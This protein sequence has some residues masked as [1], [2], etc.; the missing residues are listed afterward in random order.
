MATELITA[1][2]VDTRETAV[3]LVEAC[4]D[5]PWFKVGL[6]LFSRCGPDIVQEIQSHQKKVFLDLKF[7]DIPNTVAMAV[8]AAADSGA[9]MINV[10]ALGGTAMINAARE[11]LVKTGT[12]LLAVTILT[13]HSDAALRDELGLSESAAQAVP[14]LAQLAMKAGAHGIVCSAQEAQ[15]VRAVAGADAIIVTPGIRTSWASADDQQRITTPRDA[16]AA[17][18]DFIV[19]GRPIT[20]HEKPAEAVA[21]IL[22]ELR[23]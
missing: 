1:L 9:E 5:C 10:H 14:R 6:Q 20:Q 19:V 4:G 7:H 17:G 16:A 11:A 15:A 13:S 12:K 18:A 21:Q 2:D 22:E 3:E 23:S 8:K